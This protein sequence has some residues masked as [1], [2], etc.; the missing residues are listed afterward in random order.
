MRLPG[1]TTLD[2]CARLRRACRDA[3]GQKAWAQKN[4]VSPAYV[5]D[6]MNSRCEPGDAI[7]KAL[8]LRRV[9]R[10]V[11]VP[12]KETESPSPLPSPDSRPLQA[13]GD[14]TGPLHVELCGGAG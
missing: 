1:M 9:I 11:E 3:G 7:L 6:V 10:Y 5:S 2:V 4:G 14:D 8:N 12:G 13:D